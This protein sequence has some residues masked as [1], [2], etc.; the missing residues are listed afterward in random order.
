MSDLRLFPLLAPTYDGWA[1]PP[2][3]M[4]KVGD[5]Q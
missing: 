1:L 3:Y 2:K 4:R 5:Q